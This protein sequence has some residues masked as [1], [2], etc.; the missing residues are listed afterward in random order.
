MESPALILTVLPVVFRT[1]WTTLS[2][3]N[4]DPSKVKVILETAP[5]HD[6]FRCAQW[7]TILDEAIPGEF[8]EEAIYGGGGF[9]KWFRR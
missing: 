7:E 5:G 3:A 8:S 2:R 6:L 9:V 4:F 1:V